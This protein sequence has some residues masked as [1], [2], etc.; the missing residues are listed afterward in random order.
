MK[1]REM[2]AGD[3]DAACGLWNRTKGMGLSRADS[4]EAIGRF[5]DRNPGLSLVC[6]TEDGMLA[7][8][9]L[10]GHDGRRGYLY[11]VAM[12]EAYR[13]QGWGRR[14]AE[15]CLERLRGEGIGKCHLMVVDT[16]EVGRDFWSGTGWQYRGNILLYSRDA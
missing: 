9:A 11:H 5:L 14:L 15:G 7:G 3:Y 6:E 12:E 10:C 8:T 13:G 2:T 1:I 4:R 16:N